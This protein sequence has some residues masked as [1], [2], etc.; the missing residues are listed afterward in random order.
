MSNVEVGSKKRGRAV[1]TIQG[2]REMMGQRGQEI[3]ELK[4]RPLAE[5]SEKLGKRLVIDTETD[6]ASMAEEELVA[7]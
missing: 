7:G 2:N 3:Y 1:S 5:P 4:L 6:G